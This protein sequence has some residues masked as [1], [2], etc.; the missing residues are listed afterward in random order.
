MIEIWITGHILIFFLGAYLFYSFTPGFKNRPTAAQILFLLLAAL[1]ASLAIEAIQTFIPG[2]YFTIRDMAANIT[3]VLLYLS[4]IHR[5]ISLKLLPLHASAIAL[6]AVL[7]YPVFVSAAD[8][9]IADARFPVLADF[10]TPLEKT[11]F[12]GNRSL[13]K[14]SDKYAFQGKRSLR[15]DFTTRLYSTHSLSYIPGN[16]KGYAHLKAAVYNPGQK[17]VKLHI[18]I[19][20]TQHARS[21]NQQYTDRYNSSFDL[22]PGKWEKI[23]IPLKEIKNAPKNRKMEMEQIS[24]IM[25]F[26]ARQPEPLTL[27]IDDIRLE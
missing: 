1:A 18:R 17:P 22:P 13:L 14:I 4:F 20:D 10:E 27:Y 6:T 16:W 19:E 3:G 11:R 5:R 9:V 24:S 23:R 2:R 21:E 8:R 7:L 26:V 25:L 15:M 12:R